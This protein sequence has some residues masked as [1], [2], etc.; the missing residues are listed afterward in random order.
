MA[1]FVILTLLALSAQ[2]SITPIAPGPGEIYPMGGACPIKWNPSVVTDPAW[3]TFTIGRG[4]LIPWC[5]A[6]GAYDFSRLDVRHRPDSKCCRHSRNWKEWG[7]PQVNRIH[8][9]LSYG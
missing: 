3:S 6:F 5:I 2:A 9:A 1:T 8:L 7:R 4:F